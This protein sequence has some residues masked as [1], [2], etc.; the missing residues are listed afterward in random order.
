MMDATIWLL[1]GMNAGIA[2]V[3]A[4]GILKTADG[5]SWRIVVRDWL[6]AKALWIAT[7]SGYWAVNWIDFTPFAPDLAKPAYV[8]VLI[9]FTLFHARACVNW[10]VDVAGPV[11]A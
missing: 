5:D 6:G 2:F 4:W 10:F 7:L 8:G 9:V 1:L 11:T 3:F